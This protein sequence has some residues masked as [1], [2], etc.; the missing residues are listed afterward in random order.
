MGG[1]K[2]ANAALEG[3]GVR[4]EVEEGWEVVQVC[5]C[6]AGHQLCALCLLSSECQFWLHISCCVSR[7]L[8]GWAGA[9]SCMTEGE[10]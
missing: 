5:S 4:H 7:S 10:A 1:F 9:N 6:S 2:E 3:E 8:F